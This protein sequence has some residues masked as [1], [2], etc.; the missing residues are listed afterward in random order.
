MVR[1]NSRN[2]PPLAWTARRE[3]SR[4]LEHFSAASGEERERRIGRIVVRRVRSES[5]SRAPTPPS[6]ARTITDSDRQQMEAEKDAWL[7]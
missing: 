6:H 1:E 5:V 4:G 3:G 2:L 7:W